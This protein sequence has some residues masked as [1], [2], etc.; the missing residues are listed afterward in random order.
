LLFYFYNINIKISKHY[1]KDY[2]LTL[3]M[4]L[5][6][7][8]SNQNRLLF[9]GTG[10]AW[11]TPEL[12]C[13]CQV[14]STMRAKGEKRTR[15][16]LWLEGPARIL[17]DCG[18]DILDQLETYNLGPPDLILLT[19]EHGDHYLGLDELEAF[20]RRVPRGQFS[21]WPI[22]ATPETWAVVEVRFGYLLGKLLEKRLALPGQPLPGLEGWGLTITP[23][24]TDHG[25]TALGSI[26]YVIRHLSP[27]GPRTLVYTSDFKD[28]PEEPDLLVHPDILAAQAH[29]FNEPV[30]NRPNHMSFQRLLEFIGR[31]RPRE[32]VYLVHLSDGDLCPGES[33]QAYLKKVPASNPLK[34]P[35]TG[36]P[37]P[38]PRCQSEWQE[39]AEA[40]FAACGLTVPV[41]VAYDGLTVE[42]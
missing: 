10:A 42:L 26:G 41:T 35:A 38:I 14:C 1:R 9:L 31:W 36:R 4:P 30:F 5:S 33:D 22:Y 11:R 12:G 21:P 18:P 19:H 27:S 2:G 32:H 34:D 15:T 20:R 25:Q 24:K 13:P 23:F 17:I 16:A 7:G 3:F 28:V 6:D 40:V 37:W 8:R 39:R 29:W